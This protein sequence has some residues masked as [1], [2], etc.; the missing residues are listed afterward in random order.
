MAAQTQISSGEAL[1]HLRALAGLTLQEVA[2]E[3]DTSVAYL[4]K[5]ERS[6]LT[7]SDEYVAKIAGALSL[8]IMRLAA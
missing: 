5:V 6:V 8:S 2:N 4:S 3:A 7:P 1:R